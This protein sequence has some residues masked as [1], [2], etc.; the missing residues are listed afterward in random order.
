[1][2]NSGFPQ[3]DPDLWRRSTLD[4][5][6]SDVVASRAPGPAPPPAW[7]PALHQLA[8]LLRNPSPAPRWWTP[9]NAYLGSIETRT[10]PAGY[11]L[12]G[13]TRLARGDAPFFAFQLTLAG[14]GHYQSHGRPP[15][16][17]RPGTAFIAVVPSRHRYYL[18][19]ESPGWVFSWVSIYH[20]YVLARMTRLV[21]AAGP[22]V[23]VAPDGPLAAITT[24]LIRGSIRKDFRD[25]FEVE[26][27]LFEFLV[28]CERAMARTHS[29]DEGERL[30]DEVRS[31]VLERL[32]GA[33]DASALATEY[34]MSR[35]HFSHYFRTRTGQ[36]PARFS[37]EVRVR[38]ATRMLLETSASLAEVAAASG[39]ANANY[40]CKVF[41]RIHNMSPM[42]YRRVLRAQPANP[43]AAD[44]R[45]LAT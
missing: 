27:A 34:G 5:L 38:E 26:Q 11:Q 19:Q 22:F 8:S 31:L 42:S 12:D 30:L 20:P 2:S 14:W 21:R 41:R 32:P 4:V 24:R 3:S 16:R 39:F 13:T 10:D 43:E 28:A 6:T 44:A 18:P 33:V 45:R 9:M 15:Q 7:A 29:T 40:F 35:T 1:M 37:A 36:T 17:V 25:R 23:D